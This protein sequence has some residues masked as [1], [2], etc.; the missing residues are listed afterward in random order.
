MKYEGNLENIHRADKTSTTAELPSSE[1]VCTIAVTGAT[2]NQG[3]SVAKL[4]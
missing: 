2:D 3:G 1:Y 4:V